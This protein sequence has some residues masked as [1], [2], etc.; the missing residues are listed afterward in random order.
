MR[1]KVAVLLVVL[2]AVLA[3]FTWSEN[4]RSKGTYIVYVGT[5]TGPTSQGIYGFRFDPS[6]GKSTALGLVGESTNPS[7][8]TIDPS[9]RYLYAAN[10]V[11]DYKGA[12]S[13][14]VS[15]FA[16]DRATGKLT[17]LNEVSSRGP[18]P[19]HVALDKT[20]K[21]VLVANYDGG[22][23]AAFPVLPDGRL[24]D[25]TAFVQHSGHGPNKE[26]Q[27]RP[28]AHEVVLSP[29]NRFAIVADLGLDELLV[30]RFDPVKGTL[31]ANDP[32]YGK[33]EDGAG[34]RHF[35]FHPN[36][37]YL[38]TLNEMGGSVTA[39]AYDAHKGALRNLGAVSSLPK[40]FKGPNDSAEIAMDTSGKFLYASNRG[41]DNVAVFAV[42]TGGTL[43]LVEHVP[44]KGKTPRNFAIDP[45][46]KYLFAANQ[47]SNN[48]AVFRI[49]P[50]NGH[51]TETGQVL[52]VPSPVCI[53]FVPTN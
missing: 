13:G 50:K 40:D 23:V 11:S 22:S 8:V 2:V 46:G 42:D 19:C 20:G 44:T 1:S 51:L 12:N 7:F 25:A 34:P 6:S 52:D 30:Y 26:R 39:F 24:G 15:A 28:H 29:D 48:I 45:T 37:R 4:S 35:A 27:E 53:T 32:P 10:E 9:G 3:P 33:V 41:P 49:D 38:Y 36:G 14:G 17:F 43:K 5:Y 31:A 16:I 47:D 21:Y 18:G